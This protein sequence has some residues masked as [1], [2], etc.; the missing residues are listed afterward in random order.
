MTVTTL[1]TAQP[2]QRAP[3]AVLAPAPAPDVVYVPAPQGAPADAP[4]VFAAITSVMRDAMPVGKDQRNEQQNYQ[5]RGIDDVMSAM[6]GPMRTH[7]VFI[8]PTIAEHTQIRDGKMTRTKIT[9]RYRVYGPA[10]DC[11]I[12]DVPGEAFDYADKSTNKAQSAALKYLLFTL[13]MLPVDGRSI[14]DGDRH[15]PEPS[16]E[17]RA[18][19]QQ[20]QQRGQDRRG[21]RGQGQRQQGGQPPRRSN[22]AEPGPW[23]QQAAPP[24]P[25]RTEGPP[26]RDYLAEA[27]AAPDPAAFARV[28]SDAV[29]AGAPDD[30]LARLD[31]IAQQKA[32][33]ATPKPR[34]P[35]PPS[36]MEEAAG[37]TPHSVTDAIAAA[38]EVQ[39]AEHADAAEQR[40]RIAASR[41]GMQTLDAQFERAHGLPI[42]QAPAHLLTAMAEQIEAAVTQ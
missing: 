20:R 21:Q 35:A 19:Q 4:R 34:P 40:L 24:P 23:E 18:E 2:E 13:F 30:Y 22:R 5:F 33:Q 11:L 41:A 9:M 6:A 8:L 10:G 7:G 12:A 36:R 28:R 27:K 32:S 16:P 15:H 29:T 3:A 42:G 1:P 39:A 17:H 31:A 38:P 14:D 25:Q 26:R 37:R